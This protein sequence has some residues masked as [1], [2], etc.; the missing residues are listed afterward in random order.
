MREIILDTETTGLDPRDGHKIVEIGCVELINHVPTGN[1]FHCYLNP[2]R[3]VPAEAYNVHGLSTEFLKDFDTFNMMAE[4]FLDFV[5]E[6][7]LIIHNATFDMKF[8]NFELEAI[9]REHLKHNKVIDTLKIAR[10]KF[11]GSPASLDALCKR[12]K[13]DTTART[14]H[15]AIID[16]ELLAEVY[17]ELIGGRQVGFDLKKEESIPQKAEKV[18]N[19]QRVQREAR[20]FPA[21]AEEIQEHQRFMEENILAK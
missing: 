1:T 15:G 5:Q 8:I 20:A 16:C 12:F 14:K 21:T 18:F 2:E 3:D 10:Q 9:Q 11:P 19:M 17:L 7:P 13:I 6:D 4:A